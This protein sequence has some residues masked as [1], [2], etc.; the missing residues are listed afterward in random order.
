MIEPSKSAKTDFTSIGGRARDKRRWR[1]EVIDAR[2]ALF[3]ATLPSVGLSHVGVTLEVIESLQEYH[4][5][6]GDDMSCSAV[7]Q[8]L[9]MLPGM[10]STR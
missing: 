9:N 10:L 1:D 2:S 6:L 7:Q 3:G 8:R 4:T 5:D